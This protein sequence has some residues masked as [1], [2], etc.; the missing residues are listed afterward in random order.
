LQ[1]TNR[2]ELDQNRVKFATWQQEQQNKDIPGIRLHLGS[3]HLKFK[4]Y[5]NVDM[6]TKEADLKADVRNLPF[7]SNSISEI[8]CHHLLEHFGIRETWPIL[9]YWYSLLKPGGTISISVPDMELCFQSFLE[10]P[11]SERWSRLIYN[12]YGDETDADI[13]KERTSKDVYPFSFANTHKSGFT[14]GYL[15]R[16]LED[17]GFKMQDGYNF[18]WWGNPCLFVEA[19]KP[20]EENPPFK[21]VLEMDVCIGT[22]TNKI[23][24]IRDLWKSCQKFIPQIPFITRYNRGDIVTGMTLLREDFLKTGKRYFVFLDDDIQFL[25]SDTIKNALEYLISGKFAGI[26]IYSTFEL[27]ALTELYNPDRL[28]LVERPAKW[29]TGYFC[30]IDK[31]KAGDVIP[32]SA[33][34]DGNTSVDTSYS[35]AIRAKGYDIGISPSYVYHVKKQVWAKQDIIEITN[36]YLINKWGQFYFDWA[37]YDRN[38][39]D[40]GWQ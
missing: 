27:S 34:P 12:V 8:T 25:N 6:F 17:A 30:M 20:L 4:N 39:I 24:Y 29:M 5:I 31:L 21:S 26:T 14:L 1:P 23:T 33:L 2:I 16:L 37:I 38:V 10:G 32:D 11:E 15:I 35:V 13:P 19:I 28:E 18:F 22:F 3:G 36:K 40:S 9:Q 7:E